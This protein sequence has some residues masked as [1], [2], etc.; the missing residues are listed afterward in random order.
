MPYLNILNGWYNLY[1]EDTQ[2]MNMS[3]ILDKTTILQKIWCLIIVY[4]HKFK[5]IL[6]H[7]LKFWQRKMTQDFLYH[8][9]F[10]N[11]QSNYNYNLTITSLFYC[12]AGI[13][14]KKPNYFLEKK[15]VIEKDKEDNAC[16]FLWMY[17][18]KGVWKEMR[19]KTVVIQ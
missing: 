10:I 15:I 18:K 2:R 9:I 13:Y 14:S 6:R 1:L 4:S 5:K 19:R 12:T 3:S 8:S 16:L 7:I 11:I 17:I